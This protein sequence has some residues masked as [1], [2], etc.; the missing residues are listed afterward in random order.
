M[1]LGVNGIR[2]IGLRSGVGRAIEAFLKCMG[3][4]DHPFT[5][6][7]VYTPQPLDDSVKLP[8][9]ARN[10][11]LPSRLHPG[12]WEQFVLPKAHGTKDV[13]F[14]PSYVIPLLA[15]CPTLLAHH[16]SYEGYKDAAQAYSLW[17]RIKAR[18]MYDLSANR[19]TIVSTVSEYS[20]QDMAHYYRLAP[21]KIQVI[22]EGVDTKLFR[23]IQ[24]LGLLSRWRTQLF[25]QDVPFI[26]YV[27]KPTRRRNLS[28][29]LRAFQRLK[30]D[31]KIPHKLLL[32]GSA[33][34]GTASEQEIHDLSL[35]EHVVELGYVSHEE[36]VVCYNACDVFIY[37]SSYEGFGMPVLEA[38]ACGTSVIALNNTAFPE[39]A[40]GVARLLPDA[41][42]DTLANGIAQ[43][44]DDR[45]Q[46]EMM[47]REGPKRAK[48]YDWHIVT[49]M[50]LEQL[51]KL[52]IPK[53]ATDPIRLPDL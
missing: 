41:N 17:T 10:V 20:K 51:L 46:R 24:D 19:A 33:L 50:Y 29:L 43:L 23:P 53:N 14:C 49:G 35:R 5:T 45:A 47:A 34:P 27:G 12:L 48:K 4:M 1:I 38:M 31:N 22:P 30:Q 52:A 25:G 28:N 39:F 11:V 44:I 32:V 16:G 42:V 37:P 13:L 21:K 9:C 7:N 8:D 6:I 2:L 3:E 36:L 15:R 18:V 26:L 40:G